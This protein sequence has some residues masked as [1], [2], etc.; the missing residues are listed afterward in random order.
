MNESINQSIQHLDNIT[1]I[2]DKDHL[3]KCKSGQCQF[4]PSSP[5]VSGQYETG[6]CKS[7]PDSNYQCCLPGE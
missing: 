4:R 3:C 6:L 2:S 7:I 5:C 1:G